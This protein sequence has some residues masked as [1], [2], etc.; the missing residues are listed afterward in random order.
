MKRTQTGNPLIAILLFLWMGPFSQAQD[1]GCPQ[2]LD[3]LVDR[4]ESNYIGLVHLR[5]QGRGATYYKWKARYGKEASRTP[6]EQCTALM[7]EFLRNFGDGHLFVIERPTYGEAE[8]DQFRLQT[9]Q[10][11][12]DVSQYRP[13][14]WDPRGIEGV[15]SDG[16]SKM[17]IIKNKGIYRVHILESKDPRVSP[18]ELKAEFRL[19]GELFKGT[20]YS[21]D[22]VPR[23]TEGHLYKQGL[24]FVLTGGIYWGRLDAGP[25]LET[26]AMDPSDFRLPSIR[27]IDRNTTLFTLPSFLVDSKAMVKVLTDHL[28]LLKN[29]KLLI[30]DIR[31]NIGGNA[32]YFAFLDAYADHGLQSDQGSV[33][34]SQDTKAY[35]KRLAEKAPELYGPVV[36]RI[37]KAMGEVVDGPAYPLHTFTPFESKIAQV[38]IL[39]DQGS[40]SAS[41]TFILHSKEVS[42]RVTTFGSPTGGVVDYTSINMVSLESC[43]RH[44]VFG[45]PTGTRNKDIPEHGYNPTGIRP[46]VP[47]GEEVKDKVSFI[48][49]Y[50]AGKKTEK[51]KGQ[52]RGNRN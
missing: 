19:E 30:I 41:E 12:I 36:E 47:I 18:G 20:Y 51:A 48:V 9:R 40:M 21:Y 14:K 22:H 4:L 2:I 46:D 37:G 16:T 35:F 33:L 39:A 50:Y 24:L 3:R 13:G 29:T 1:C 8:L 34:A 44:V 10:H 5:E 52:S 25:T 27:T 26:R 31:G 11:A 15:W 43:G 28:E 7:Q 38:A 23:Y 49:D 32:L 17:A 45:Y 42:G 6:L